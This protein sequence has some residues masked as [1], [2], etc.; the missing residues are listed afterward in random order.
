MV[1]RWEQ[2]GAQVKI[3]LSLLGF[4]FVACMLTV[5]LPGCVSTGGV[6]YEGGDYYEPYG[7]DYGGWGPD[8]YVVPFHGEHHDRYEH[9]RAAE[10]GHKERAYRSAPASRPIPSIPSRPRAGGSRSR[11]IPTRR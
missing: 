1:G 4:F 9:H 10:D 6:Y 2:R 3:L 7:Y 5:L 11:S 8:F